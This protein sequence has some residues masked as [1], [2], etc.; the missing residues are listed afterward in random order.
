[1]NLEFAIQENPFD[2]GT[3]IF[4]TGIKIDLFLLEFA[5]MKSSFNFSV[6]VELLM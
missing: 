6:H 1:M 4:D 2:F 3:G 5:A